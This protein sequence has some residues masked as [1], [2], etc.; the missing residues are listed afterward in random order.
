MK[1]SALIAAGMR[2]MGLLISLI[3]GAGLVVSL[4][5]FVAWRYEKQRTESF[6]QVAEQLGLPF[7]P[8]GN[9]AL[10][11][12]L[13]HL[14]LFSQGRS[15]KIRNMLHGE[16][17]GLELAVMD[18][19]YTVG[20]G[21]NSQTLRQ[22]VI[23]F[24]TPALNLT[25]FAVR[26]ESILHRIGSAFGYQD[27][28][29]ATHPQFSKLYLLR[30]DDESAIRQL[31]TDKVLTFFQNEHRI[32]AEGSGDQLVFYRQGKRIKPAELPDFIDEGFRVLAVFRDSAQPS[33]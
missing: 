4:I 7:F 24:Q 31:F 1:T 26:P 15:R 27:I 21:K 29:F 16:A 28:D 14:H 25:K 9:E 32:C 13:S 3:A 22:G 12:R 33:A 11:S 10:L 23:Y 20:S 2:D 19:Q 30:G 5:L 8:T 17:R 18:Y 6:R